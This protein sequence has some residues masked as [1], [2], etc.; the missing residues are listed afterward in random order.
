A[1]GLDRLYCPHEFQVG[2]KR[3]LVRTLNSA[4]TSRKKEGRMLMLPLKY[5]AERF[6]V[7]DNPAVAV[8]A[9]HHPYNWFEPENARALRK[10]LEESSDVILTGHEHSSS[11]Y[12]KT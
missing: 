8:T 7:Q 1:E 3:I 5:L 10:L 11:T 4:W 9:I 12:V 2:G 6:P